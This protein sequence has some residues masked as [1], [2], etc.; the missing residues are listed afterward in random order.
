MVDDMDT[1]QDDDAVKRDRDQL[2]KDEAAE[3]HAAARQDAARMDLGRPDP[4]TS[5]VQANPARQDPPKGVQPPAPKH[6]KG[7]EGAGSAVMNQTSNVS[8]QTGAISH[9]S[10]PAIVPANPG[11]PAGPDQDNLLVHARPF[12]GEPPQVVRIPAQHGVIPPI[13]KIPVASDQAEVVKP[14]AQEQLER[15]EQNERDGLHNWALNNDDR[16]RPGHI[17]STAA[18]PGVGFNPVPEGSA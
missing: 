13:P 4:R 1:S 18:V 9:P 2:A 14:V 10:V 11:G 17:A 16:R 15:S 7:D 12:T 6:I 8:G 5:D 3:K